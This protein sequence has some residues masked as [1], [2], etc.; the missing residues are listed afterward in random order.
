MNVL[1]EIKNFALT[2]ED[3]IAIHSGDTCLSYGQLNS[4]SDRLA[5]WIYRNYG[6]SKIPVVVYGHKNPYMIVCFLACV[7]AGKA[8][9]PQDISIPDSRVIDTVECV[10]PEIIFQVEGDIVLENQNVINLSQVKEI[11]EKE[12]EAVDASVCVKPEDTYYIIFTSGSTGKPKG[13]QITFDCLNNYLDWSVTLGST[14]SEK[15]GKNFGNQ[16]PF[17][18]DLSV[19]DLYTCLACGGT[20][21]T[22]TKKMQEDYGAMFEH[23]ENA[24][25][26]IWV[27]TPSFADMCLAD[28]KFCSDMMPNL[29]MFLFCGEVLTTSTVKKLHERFPSAKVINTYGPTESTVAVSD[30]LITSK[31]LESTMIKGK[32]LPV[33]H[34]KKGTWL[35]IHDENGNCLSEGEQGEI[36]IIGNTVSTGYYQREDLTKK[37]FFECDREG[38]TYRAYHTGDAGYK[39]DGQ[40]YYN[41]RIDLQVK[42]N[43]YRIEVEDIENNML[44]LPQIHHA[45]VMPNMKEGKVRSLTAFVTGDLDGKTPQ[46]FGRE[47]KKQLKD[48]LPTYMIPKKVKYIEEIPMNHNGKADRKFLGGLL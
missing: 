11:I 17:S 16:A 7:K 48:I 20:L 32:S 9:C 4:Y 35:E 12:K 38:R 33:G 14:R 30:V 29:E 15:I 45:V 6:D 34:E 23:F 21:H 39:I 2:D 36:I 25:I 19:M 42:L 43:G 5:A 28:K 31:L 44:R 13:V 40:L 27:S 3:R 46:E 8:Y 37:A 41:G 24:D 47:V 1:E 26:N 10:E 22:M 18:F